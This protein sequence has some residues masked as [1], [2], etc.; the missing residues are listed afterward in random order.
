MRRSLGD[1]WSV[2]LSGSWTRE[3]TDDGVTRWHVSG[4]AM[5]AGPGP[6]WRCAD[7]ADIIASLDAELPPNP[8]AKVG[9]GG[10]DG[11][12]HRAAWLYRRDDGIEFTLHGFT[13]VD[14]SSTVGARRLLV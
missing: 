2:E 14:G 7:G 8:T 13:F 1:G 11:V 10:R 3:T 6:S 5:R 4:R 12:G 9:E